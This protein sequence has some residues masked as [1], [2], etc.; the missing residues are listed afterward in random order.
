M[1][2]NF[3][4]PSKLANG[5]TAARLDFDLT[6]IFPDMNKEVMNG[7]LKT[8]IGQVFTIDTREIYTHFLQ[9][10]DFDLDDA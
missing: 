1:F 4:I 7:N 6:H 3:G 8:L 9:S 10:R 2:L 5:L